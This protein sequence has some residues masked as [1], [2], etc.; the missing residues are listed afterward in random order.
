MLRIGDTGSDSV[1]DGAIVGLE[2]WDLLCASASSLRRASSSRSNLITVRDYQ[3]E[4]HERNVLPSEDLDVKPSS[5]PHA[6]T[7]YEQ[8]VCA[9]PERRVI[10]KKDGRNTGENRVNLNVVS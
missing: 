5:V 3:H 9:R 8:D 7:E 4:P 6:H 1:S 10:E 2:F